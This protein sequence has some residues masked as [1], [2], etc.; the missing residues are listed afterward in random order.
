MPVPDTLRAN[1]VAAFRYIEARANAG[2]YVHRDDIDAV[3]GS[4]N[5]SGSTQ[6][7]VCR[8]LERLGLIVTVYYQRGRQF[9]IV[10]TGAT[11]AAPRCTTPHWRSLP[12]RGAATPPKPATYREER[13]VIVYAD[14]RICG[15]C[16]ARRTRGC[17]HYP[18]QSV[19]ALKDVRP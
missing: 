11:T 7:G 3:L 18:L 5:S 19:E 6:A 17:E 1:H 15:R 16:G 10:A 12:R 9:T 2:L 14:S 13:K 8:I 4:R